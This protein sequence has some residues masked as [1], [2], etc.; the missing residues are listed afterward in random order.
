MYTAQAVVRKTAQ[1]I[2]SIDSILPEGFAFCAVLVEIRRVVMSG[3][4]C[5]S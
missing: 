1:L 5:F 3:F 4:L 2:D